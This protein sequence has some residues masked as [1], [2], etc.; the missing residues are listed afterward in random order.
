MIYFLVLAKVTMT[1]RAQAGDFIC[2]LKTLTF[3]SKLFIILK[4]NGCAQFRL[5]LI[6]TS[7]FLNS[8]LCFD[9]EAMLSF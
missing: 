9:F 1:Y 6:L 8:P 3:K 2:L 5:R 4:N 7:V